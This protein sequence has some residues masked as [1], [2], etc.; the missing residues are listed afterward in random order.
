MDFSRRYVSPASFSEDNKAVTNISFNCIG[1]TVLNREFFLL[2]SAVFFFFI[3]FSPP[4]AK[5]GQSGASEIIENFNASLLESMKRADE[6]GFSGRYKILY[7]VIQDSFAL[8]FMAKK[9][10]GKYRKI[11][12]SEEIKLLLE[13][14][15]EWTIATYA[16]RFDS[17]SGEKFKLLSEKETGRGTLTVI[18]QLVKTSGDTVDFYYRTRKIGNKWRIVDIHISGVSQLAL[19]R[20]QFVS[21]LKKDGFDGLI[22]KLKKSIDE[23][24]SDKD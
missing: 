10:I 6:L 22:A 11:L 13:V 16:A 7:P 14:Y 21:V 4:D 17:Y 20:S 1:T 15:T 18:T 19:T 8:S 12:S 3:S 9:S 24:S 23:L 5:A 2:I